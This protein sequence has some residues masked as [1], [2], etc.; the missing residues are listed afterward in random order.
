MKLSTPRTEYPDVSLWAW[1]QDVDFDD[2]CQ[3]ALHVN[4]N[5]TRVEAK[6]FQ[7]R[8]HEQGPLAVPTINPLEEWELASYADK[9]SPSISQHGTDSLRRISFVR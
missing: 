1:L 6:R 5:R 3:P 9:D 4:V 8:E 2:H 7:P